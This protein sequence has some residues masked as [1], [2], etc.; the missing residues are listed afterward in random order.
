MYGLRVWIDWT[1]RKTATVLNRVMKPA[2]RKIET[3]KKVQKKART[4]ASV[5]GRISNRFGWGPEAILCM[6]S[7]DKNPRGP[8][9]FNH[10][11]RSIS[12]FVM[13]SNP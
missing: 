6:V 1:Q 9:H 7:M 3:T 5:W 12:R 8:Y 10:S 13:V 4:A 2:V 11:G